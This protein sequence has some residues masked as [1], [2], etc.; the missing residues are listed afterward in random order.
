LKEFVGNW[1]LKL[2][3]AMNHDYISASR[4]ILPVRGE[5]VDILYCTSEGCRYAMA[6]ENV[7]GQQWL[8]FYKGGGLKCW[9]RF[10]VCKSVDIGLWQATLGLYESNIEDI[11]LSIGDGEDKVVVTELIGRER[12]IQIME[13]IPG[14]PEWRTSLVLRFE[15]CELNCLRQMERDF[16]GDDHEVEV[17]VE[18]IS[19][20]SSIDD[21]E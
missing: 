12:W 20:D 4:E 11:A 15:R 6:Y 19:S 9:I 1:L 17:E 18:E 8:V 2:N 5:V 10:L 7:D 3:L 21:K 14:T 16:Q 13:R